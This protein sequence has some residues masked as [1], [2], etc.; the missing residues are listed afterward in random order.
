M[1]VSKSHDHVR[2]VPAVVSSPITPVL[3]RLGRVNL[4]HAADLRVCLGRV[5]DRR[6]R[7]G[8]RYSLASM[9]TIAAVAVASGARSVLVIWD[10]VN[11]LPLWALRVLGAWWSPHR[12]RFVG[13]GRPR[14]DAC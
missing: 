12:N 6:A 11:D 9:L 4:Q 8:A 2:A 1:W 10:W 14:Y 7:R 13:L 3:D 5:T